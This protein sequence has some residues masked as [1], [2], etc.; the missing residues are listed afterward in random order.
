MD[1]IVPPKPKQRDGFLRRVA[2]HQVGIAAG[3]HDA[4]I[5]VT[6]GEYGRGNDAMIS[7]ARPVRVAA[8]CIKNYAVNP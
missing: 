6:A 8:L 4:G 7:R 3:K 1:L 2:G 5:R